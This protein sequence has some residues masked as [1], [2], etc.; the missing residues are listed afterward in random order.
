MTQTLEQAPAAEASRPEEKRAERPIGRLEWA[1]F[2][3]FFG[4]V[5][6]LRLFE[7]YGYHFDSDESQH[8][9]V[10]WG[11]TKGLVQYRDTFDNHTPLFHLLMAPILALLGERADIL[12]LMRMV[13]LPLFAVTLWATSALGRSLFSRRAG[14]W[15]AVFLG[16]LPGFFFCSIEFRTDDLWVMFWML[17]LL[18]FLGGAPSPKRFLLGG[19]ILGAALSTSLKTILML[20]SLGGAGLIL[21]LLSQEF[22]RSFS[23]RQG[24]RCAGAAAAGL[25]ILPVLLMILF[26]ALGAWKQFVYCIITHNLVPEKHDTGA[27]PE[28]YVRAV[29]QLLLFGFAAWKASR[30][31]RPAGV[32]VAVLILTAGLFYVSLTNF[33]PV[34]QLQTMLPVFPL[35]VLAIVALPYTL[36]EATPGAGRRAGFARAARLA[37]PWA[38]GLF[39]LLESGAIAHYAPPWQNSTRGAT[40]LLADVLKLTGPT[41]TIMDTKGETVYRRRGYYY[42]LE[43]FT[44]ERL[45]RQMMKDTIVRQCIKNQTCVVVNDRSRIPLKTRRF[46]NHEYVDIGRLSVVGHI[47]SPQATAKGQ[48]VRFQTAIATRYALIADKIQ[49]AGKLDG[50]PYQGPLFLAAG[51]HEFIPD[52]SEPKLACFWAQA[53]ERGFNPFSVK[54]PSPSVL[55]QRM[56]ARKARK[57]SGKGTHVA[58]ATDDFFLFKVTR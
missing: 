2:F 24:L 31:G 26:Y 14:L 4:L 36:R 46:F 34:M 28:Q 10:A 25:C 1:V 22:R 55:A 17:A 57:L 40:A 3:L 27:H 6:I 52:Q 13:M 11:W 29:I 45:G 30:S 39:A 33:W 43:K 16:L 54:P 51:P 50:K 35:V 38:C 32:R 48:P 37:T 18:T 41:D 23:W 58:N 47:L 5:L 42:V 12:N 8:L 9:H 20:T 49:A 53:W 19:F 21:P 7:I 44:M 56:L 15:A